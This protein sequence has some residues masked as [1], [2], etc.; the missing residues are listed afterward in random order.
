MKVNLS[1]SRRVIFFVMMIISQGYLPFAFATGPSVINQ[2]LIIGNLIQ[3]ETLTV[4]PG[5]WS[6]AP[7]S[8]TFQWFR[9]AAETFDSCSSITGATNSSYVLNAADNGSRIQASVAALPA[10]G[11]TTAVSSISG[12][13]LAMPSVI[14]LPTISGDTN[15]GTALSASQGLWNANVIIAFYQ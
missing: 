1:L 2:P 13:V 11:G 9:C 3:G 7:S 8:L 15:R 4:S 5:N 14:S 6:I 10:G 12:I